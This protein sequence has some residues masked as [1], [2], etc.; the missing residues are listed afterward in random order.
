MPKFPHSGY[1]ANQSAGVF[2]R[3]QGSHSPMVEPEIFFPEDTTHPFLVILLKV[4]NVWHFKVVPGTVNSLVPTLDGTALDS[5]PAP[6]K[7]LGGAPGYVYLECKYTSGQSFP[8][9]ADLKVKYE[10]TVPADTDTMSHVA[11]A[12]IEYGGATPK[13]TAQYVLTSLWGERLKCGT[14]PAEYFYTRA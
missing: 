13:K 5:T 7:S 2:V 6:T 8:V 1:S 3:A 11:L 12:Y 4:S 9:A 10:T 14:N